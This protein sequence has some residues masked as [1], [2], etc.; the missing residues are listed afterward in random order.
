MIGAPMFHA[1]GFAHALLDVGLGSTL[2]A[3]PPLR[4]GA[5][6]RRASSEHARDRLVVVPVMLQRILDARR[7]GS[8]RAT[9][10][11]AADRLL[12]R[13]AA[14]RPSS[15]P[16]ARRVRR[17]GLQPLRLDRGRLRHDRHAGGSARRAR[18]RRA[19]RRSGTD[20]RLFDDGGRAGRRAAG[21]GASSSATASRSRATPAAATRRSIDGLMSTGDVGHFDA[22]GRLFIDGRDDEM[23]VSG[24]ENVFPREV[25]E[26]LDAHPDVDEAAVIGVPDDEF[27]QR[28][29]AFVVRAPGAELER[30][31]GPGLRARRTSPAS[32]CRATSCSSTSCRATPPARCSSAS[33]RSG[34]P[35]EPATRG[36]PVKHAR[37][38]RSL[39]QLADTRRIAAEV[40]DDPTG[41][42]GRNAPLYGLNAPRLAVPRTSLEAAVEGKVAMVTGA[43]SGIGRASALRIGRSRR[44]GAA[45]RARGRGA[46]GGAEGDRVGWRQGARARLR[47]LRPVGDR[48]PRRGRLGGGAT[49]NPRQQRR[50]LDLAL[51]RALPTRRFHDNQR[52]SSA[53][54]SAPC[55]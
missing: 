38:S 7:R 22:A 11:R 52:T 40:L 5:V 29:R 49:S 23:I 6:A 2:V 30:G 1:L 45:G 17:R 37:S 47:P 24:G 33:W 53:T 42:V 12:R 15:R 41:I 21:P 34:S 4:P 3:A 18:R 43:S 32:R 55:G 19:G 9:S 36:R 31:R 28:L 54:T 16:R 25:E 20:V 8:P 13:L 51:G 35:A 10:S 27:G 48:A 26:L 39:A 46:R 14:R 50:A 44:D